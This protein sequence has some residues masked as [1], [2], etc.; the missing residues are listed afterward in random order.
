VCV[1]TDNYK[2]SR[3]TKIGRENDIN[4]SRIVLNER[5]RRLKLP[6]SEVVAPE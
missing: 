2:I 6:N 4:A 1:E 3:K 5:M